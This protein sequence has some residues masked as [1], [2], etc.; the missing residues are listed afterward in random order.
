M[1]TRA[2]RPDLERIYWFKGTS[3]VMEKLRGVGFHDGEVT[4]RISD[5]LGP[6]SLGTAE[7]QQHFE[8]VLR[9]WEIKVR[10]TCCAMNPGYP[11]IWLPEELK[12]LEAMVRERFGDEAVEFRGTDLGSA[13]HDFR[14]KPW[15]FGIIYHVACMGN[16]RAVVDEQLAL[17]KDAGLNGINVCML[18]NDSERTWLEGL[19]SSMGLEFQVR[20]QDPEIRLYEVPA[21]RLLADWAQSCEEGYGLYFHTKGVSAPDCQIRK[22]WRWLMGE[23]VVRRW[24]ENCEILQEGY[25]AVGV[26][27]KPMPPISHFAGNFFMARASFL[28]GLEEF[29]HYYRNPRH[30]R[31]WN[32]D[33]IGA[34]FWIGSGKTAPKVFSRVSTG[35]WIEGA[36]Y[37]RRFSHLLESKELQPVDEMNPIRIRGVTCAY[38]TIETDGSMGFEDLHVTNSPGFHWV[39]S[40]HAESDVIIQVSS[41]VRLR[42]FLNGSAGPCNGA[43]FLV[44]GVELGKVYAAHDVTPE[45]M[46][47]A[48]EHSLKI[49]PLD[50]NAHCHSVWG[51]D[52]PITVA[53]ASPCGLAVAAHL[54][55]T[56][57]PSELRAWAL[58]LFE[59]GVDM[60]FL[61]CL[62]EKAP[63][64]ISALDSDSLADRVRIE[65]LA[66]CESGR[67]ED[68]LGLF[69]LNARW[70]AFVEF[71]EFLVPQVGRSLSLILSAYEE[72]GGIEVGRRVPIESAGGH[73]PGG[74]AIGAR[75]FSVMES[76]WIVQPRFVDHVEDGKPVF[77]P[78]RPAT[79]E[80]FD[81]E[82]STM[83]LY[84]TKSAALVGPIVSATP[85]VAIS[86]KVVAS[87]CEISPQKSPEVPGI[88]GFVHVAA[89]NHWR[90]V[91]R[92]QLLKMESS[93]LLEATEKIVV[94]V[95]GDTNGGA[96]EISRMHP[97]LTVAFTTRDLA[98]FEF[99]TLEKLQDHCRASGDDVWY[100]HS[101]G[102]ANPWQGQAEWR[103]RMEAFVLV[104]HQLARDKLRSGNK[105]AAGFTVPGDCP[106][107]GNFWWARADH[108]SGLPP[109]ST[110]DHADRWEAERWI[111]KCGV[112]GFYWYENG[113][114]ASSLLRIVGGHSAAGR[115]TT[116][117]WHGWMRRMVE[118]DPSWPAG[119]LLSAHAPSQ[120]FIEAAQPLAVYGFTDGTA[121]PRGWV[122][123]FKVNGCLL[124]SCKRRLERTP[125]IELPAGNHC[126]DVE[127]VDGEIWGAHTVWS[128]SAL[129]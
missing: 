103:N 39:V 114:P 121:V 86:K 62:K 117:G 129:Q 26:N 4:E 83:Y 20:F 125:R 53:E 109:I 102:V 91:F 81:S 76:C 50:G 40:A 90:A 82:V 11:T 88:T 113:D 18:G 74:A 47:E 59:I 28:R 110:L 80:H 69:R 5:L 73:A 52:P 127:V 65:E 24:R 45:R 94:G 120:L 12:H 21:I 106:V 43:A 1:W 100:I 22:N 101:K 10:R 3:D 128:V 104:C 89:V 118:P 75:R 55:P 92:A 34:E 64:V 46:I 84:S 72:Y 68:L 27:W 105:V 87:G 30:D 122:A 58:S 85:A 95:V 6:F 42:G 35:E 7:R 56:F 2:N 41:A 8:S 44:D 119:Q 116:N 31:D 29:S 98:M 78:G 38:G 123:R 9:E 108:I 54:P 57:D 77:M 67:F 93:G 71:G 97:K 60:L 96:E 32:Y 111:G 36:D 13:L 61:T 17:M 79:G 107:P 51:I 23:H 14:M 126:L 19:A 115:P 25:D 48:G 49:I 99:P 70:L 16:W 124:G 63:R 112:A 66:G 15:Q 37:W 33:R